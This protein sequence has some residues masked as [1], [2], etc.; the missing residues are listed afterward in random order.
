MVCVLCMT[1]YIC[2]KI[3]RWNKPKLMKLISNVVEE[4]GMK[5]GTINIF[6]YYFSYPFDFK[7]CVTVPHKIN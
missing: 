7:E 4:N 2:K 1:T 6:K 3:Q 5:E